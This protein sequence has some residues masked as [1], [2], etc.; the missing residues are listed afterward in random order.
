M[1]EMCN[2]VRSNGSSKSQHSNSSGSSGY[3]GHASSIQG[4]R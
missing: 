4:S 1:Q 2:F 3:G